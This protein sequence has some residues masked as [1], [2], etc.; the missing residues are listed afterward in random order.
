MGQIGK[1]KKKTS[2]I[3]SKGSNDEKRRKTK[4]QLYLVK[5]NAGGS[6]RMLFFTRRDRNIYP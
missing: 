1:I 5:I 3:I 2:T 4:R 6:P